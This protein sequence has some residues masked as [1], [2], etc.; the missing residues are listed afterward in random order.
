MV[1]A[2]TLKPAEAKTCSTCELFNNYNL[3]DQHGWCN[4]F[5][6]PARTFHIQTNDCVLNSTT[7]EQE[8]HF[9]IFANYSQ[10]EL[11]ALREVAFPTKIV[12]MDD[13]GYPMGD[14][15][16]ANAYF[17]PNFVTL[18]NEPF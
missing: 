9:D 7:R 4:L 13:E 8:K 6:L 18:P 12:W 11:E 10:K 3:P 17:D 16:V 1:Q 15:P 14:N 5:D 2:T